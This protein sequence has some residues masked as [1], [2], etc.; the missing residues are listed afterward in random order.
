MPDNQAEIEE[1]ARFQHEQALRHMADSKDWTP[2]CPWSQLVPRRKRLYRA[3]AK[4]VLERF[5]AE[6][7][8]A[9]VRAEKVNG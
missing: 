8:N 1:L 2:G 3:V 7:V 5:Q 9:P 6:R 4:A